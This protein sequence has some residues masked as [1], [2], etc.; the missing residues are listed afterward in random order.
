MQIYDSC[1]NI[2]S[3]DSLGYLGKKLYKIYEIC[4]KR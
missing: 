4:E 2:M 3:L 1:L